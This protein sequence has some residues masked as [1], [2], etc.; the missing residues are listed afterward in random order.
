MLSVWSF[1]KYF[2]E[3]KSGGPHIWKNGS[4]P[5]QTLSEGALNHNRAKVHTPKANR[6]IVSNA[7]CRYKKKQATQSGGLF[8]F[9]VIARDRAGDLI[10][11]DVG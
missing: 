3:A 9:S 8:L 1:S 6:E 7:S 11:H 4:S 10:E 5:L 2:R